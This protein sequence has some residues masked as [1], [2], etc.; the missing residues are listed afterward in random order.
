VRHRKQ[1]VFIFL[2]GIWLAIFDLCFAQPE[3]KVEGILGGEKRLAVV[4]GEIIREGDSVDGA[5][6]L[7]IGSDSVKFQYQGVVF[8]KKLDERGEKKDVH[9]D[10]KSDTK[11][12]ITNEIDITLLLD[13]LGCK[14]RTDQWNAIEALG[15]LG[16]RRAVE[17]LL[18]ILLN[19]KED[20]YTRALAAKA[21]GMMDDNRAVKGLCSVLKITRTCDRG[22]SSIPA[23]AAEALARIGD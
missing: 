13:M 7:E 12:N 11:E 21:L 22:Y 2:A 8:I 9:A 1:I 5:I 16:D 20:D 4:N 17:P 19:D 6:V 14:K 23:N 3:L 10:R 15:R 18:R